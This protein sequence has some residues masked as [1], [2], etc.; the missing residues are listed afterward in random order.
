MREEDLS[1]FE[2][3]EFK[4]NLAR[5]EEMMGKGSS[6]YLDS[7][8]LTDI[9]EYYLVNGD[10]AEANRCIDYALALH[11]GATDPLIFRARQHL[12]QGN[13]E[14]AL[15]IREQITENKET[16]VFFLDA[17]ILIKQNRNDEAHELLLSAYQNEERNNSDF[18]YDCAC[19][20]C[21]YI[22]YQRAFIW[23]SQALQLNPKSQKAIF[24]K[25]DIHFEKECFQECIDALEQLLDVN[26]YH[27][28]AWYMMAE[29]Y[30]RQE[31]Y[32]QALDAADFCLAI[33]ED[34]K[35]IWSL[36][37]YVYLAK[38][39]FEDACV[40][41][42]KCTDA[43]VDDDSIHSQYGYCLSALERY[44]ESIEQLQKAVENTSTD[45][46]ELQ[47]VYLQMAYV[48]SKLRDKDKAVWSLDY[49]YKLNPDLK[50]DYKRLK[51][52]IY[53]EHDDLLVAFRLFQEAIDESAH[54]EQTTYLIALSL[55]DKELYHSASEL[56]KNLT[57]EPK[58][59]F[60]APAMPYLAYSL[61]KIGEGDDY[62]NALKEAVKCDPETTAEIFGEHFFGV[63]PTEYFK[64]AYKQVH[65]VFPA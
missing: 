24:L 38:E 2:G 65:G 57:Y 4:K 16:E 10:S 21:D 9:A 11:P 54:A 63:H 22:D 64:Y 61:M 39:C 23:T 47:K 30:L 45:D 46:P 18:C 62:L 29:A 19:V 13:I 44:D 60:Y 7:D 51:A 43:Q 49:A 12:T 28:K 40:W 34:Y 20:F 50:P 33:D 5:Y 55:Y 25:A 53:L 6:V 14:N 15:M 8:E 3:E 37:A 58:A 52:C 59:E 56:L 26:P 32:N 35:H 42:K 48:Y 36:K 41:Y 27:I 31:N 1:Y 17:E